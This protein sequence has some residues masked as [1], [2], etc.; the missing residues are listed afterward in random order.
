M[1]GSSNSNSESQQT[2]VAQTVAIGTTYIFVSSLLISFNKYLMHPNRFSHAT[3][4]TMIHMLTTTLLSSILYRC[5]PQLYP[6]MAQAKMNKDKIY[7]SMVPLGALFAVA[8]VCSNLAYSYSSVAF[9]QFCKQGNVALMF[10][11]S[12]IVGVQVFSWNKVM[13]LSVIITGCCLCAHGEIHFVRLGL[14]L[15]LCSQF[16]ECS[17]NLLGELIMSRDLKLDV[18]TFVFFQA[19]FSLLFL[20]IGAIGTYTPEVKKDFLNTWHLLLANALV[21]FLLNVLIALTL[22]KLSALA[23][24]LIGICK[25]ALIVASSAVVF[26]DAISPAQQCGFLVTVCGIVLWSHLK[27]QEQEQNDKRKLLQQ[28]MTYGSAGEGKAESAGEKNV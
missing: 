11:M 7:K 10:I 18:L 21:A 23:F 5:A 1:A 14:I 19:P 13:A 9:L 2:T 3:H 4:L 26:D 17:K 25:D 27:I 22:K 24:V 15:Q 16:F 28:S 20:L 8:L 12:C 6:S